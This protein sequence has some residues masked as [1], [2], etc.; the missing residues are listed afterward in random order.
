MR[1]YFDE[2]QEKHV[3]RLRELLKGLPPFV[4]EFMNGLADNTTARTRMGYAYDIGVFLNFM[5]KEAR[6]FDKAVLD[7]TLADLEA[8]TLTDIEEFK[9]YLDYYIKGDG[10][11]VVTN[12]AIGKS[13]KLSAIRAMY[14][15]FQKKGKIEKNPT[16]LVEFPKI[17]E[18]AIVRLET[19][20]VARL[21]DIVENGE[22]LTPKQKTYHEYTKLRD[23]AI[24]SLM[25]GTGV[26][27]SECAGIDIGH[28]DF[29]NGGLLI[30]RKGGS[31]ALI[32]IGDEVEEALASYLDVREEIKGLPGHEDA[33]FLSLQKKRIGVRAIQ[34]IV[35]KYA[36]LVTSY[37]K[38]TPHKLRSTFG[39]N[40]YHATEDI[41]LVADVLGHKSVDTTRKHYADMADQNRRKAARAVRLRT[42]E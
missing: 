10:E 35:K 31:Q 37:K 42:E 4:R 24:I 13:R 3:L 23:L 9:A 12:H 40:L 11:R 20:E 15:Y 26:R 30:T 8:V 22:G 14:R 36:E 19:N 32:Y 28:V 41:Y 39:T 38:I 29:E 21:L 1:N 6:G 17:S 27:V 34:N 18:K 16:D 25:L 33:L 7:I 5:E 2:I